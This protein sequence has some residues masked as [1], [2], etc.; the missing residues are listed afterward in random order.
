M[1]ICITEPTFKENTKSIGCF[2]I[3]DIVKKNGYDI[4]YIDFFDLLKCDMKFDIYLFSI[5]HVKDLFFLLKILNNKNIMNGIKI[6]GGHVMNN[7]YPF[8]HFFDLICIGEGEDWILKQLKLY[9]EIKN[10]NKYLE[11]AIRINGTLSLENKQAEIKKQYIDDISINDIYLN[12]SF[13]AGH[14][15]TWYIEIARGCK[16]KCYYC[17]LG[18]SNYYR[19]NNFEKIKRELD[20]IKNS[21]CKKIN[22]FAPDNYSVKFYNECLEEIKKRNLQT[23]FGSMKIE[24][25]KN[26]NI[27]NKKNFLFRLGIDGLSERLRKIIN[28]QISNKTIIETIKKLI[29][30]GFVM[31]KFFYIFSYPWEKQED[32]FEFKM[33]MQQLINICRSLKRPIF[34]RLKFTPFIPNLLTPL[35]NF[36][37]NYNKKMRINIENFFIEQKMNKTNIV[38]INDGILEPWSYYTQTFLTRCNY[39]DINISLL[40]NRKQF[41]FLSEKKCKEIKINNKI[42]TKINKG[43]RDDIYNKLKRK[44][45]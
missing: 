23:N 30:N 7:P 12:K 26:M 13:A 22:I 35:E 6:A 36:T 40:K 17:E 2:F 3:E 41:N 10:K 24:H 11:E 45:L 20:K 19:E 4:Q 8:L 28:K 21:K 42:I 29:E 5:H 43:K 32:F 14:S 27:L 37:P 34:L 18:W 25:F 9:E 33:L 15:D 31:F 1:K 39:E 38:F 44:Y 16:S